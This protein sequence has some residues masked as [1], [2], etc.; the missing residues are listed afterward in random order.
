MLR[1]IKLCSIV[2]LALIAGCD[3]ASAKPVPVR[4]V[5]EA[6][7]VESGKEAEQPVDPAQLEMVD[8]ASLNLNPPA[9]RSTVLRWEQ[10]L[11]KASKPGDVHVPWHHYEPRGSHS[12]VLEWWT[13]EPNQVSSYGALQKNSLVAK[14]DIRLLSMHYHFGD[15]KEGKPDRAHVTAERISVDKWSVR[16]QNASSWPG[17][18]SPLS[19]GFFRQPSATRK[20]VAFDVL[21]HL[22]AWRKRMAFDKAAYEFKISLPEYP[23]ASEAVESTQFH[24]RIRSLSTSPESFRETCHSIVNELEQLLLKSLPSDSAIFQVTEEQQVPGTGTDGGNPTRYRPQPSKRPLQAEEWEAV[25]EAA[26]AEMAARRQII[27]EHAAEMHE[28]LV[29]LLPVHELL[30]P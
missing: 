24:S 13:D 19:L 23:S 17:K 16:F 25:L 22:F 1:A 14:V 29:D 5:A 15:K 4:P 9:L 7:K 6:R 8:F 10:V 26:R 12:I 27:D 20:Y 30:R 21:P 2:C 18:Y 28:A 11:A 3:G